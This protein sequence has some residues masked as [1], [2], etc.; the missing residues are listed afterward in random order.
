MKKVFLT[1]AI[2]LLLT[3]I[4]IY[5]T[6][7]LTKNSD[8]LSNSA[9]TQIAMHTISF[10][11]T[12]TIPT[13]GRILISFP[14]LINNDVN[15]S[16]SASASTFQLNGLT[17]LQIKI[18]EGNADLTAT[19]TISTTNSTGAG[20]SP[21]ISITNNGSSIAANT[22]ITVYLGC[23]QTNGV[24]CTN[25]QATVINPGKTNA[26]GISDIWK[27]SVITYDNTSNRLESAIIQI[28][29]DDT[30]NIKATI[31][32]FMS[33]IIAG[34]PD[35]TTINSPGYC[36]PLHEPLTTNAGIAANA[37]SVGLGILIS[38]QPHYAAQTLTLFSN[39]LSGYAIVAT[40]SGNM[41]G[42][43][44][45]YI[46]PN[47]QGA[48]TS[49]NIP[50]PLPLNIVNESFGIHACD[51]RGKVNTSFWGT[52][53]IKFA[54]PSQFYY[55]LALSNYTPSVNG[56]TIVIVYGMNVID[57]TPGG[58]YETTLTYIATP[59]F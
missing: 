30:V 58:F 31:L 49:A 3:H 56:D 42:V 1:I 12:Q 59:L 32:P 15:N 50:A 5:K 10:T 36:G 16:A 22:V 37:T 46:I 44:S 27:I 48:P 26:S 29:T 47:T 2:I 19:T 51:T 45:G 39:G 54:N 55:T 53:P 13:N 34:L 33:F 14:A 6:F 7:A 40:G 18:T 43:S 4:F 17:G 57:K 9:P 35:G 21:S 41:K 23:T 38:Q 8:R 11:T 24:T 20:S 28:A 52:S 25:T